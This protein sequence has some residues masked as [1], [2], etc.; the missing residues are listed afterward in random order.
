MII[1][2][3]RFDSYR[4]LWFI[5]YCVISGKIVRGPRPIFLYCKCL[6]I[7]LAPEFISYE[8]DGSITEKCIKNLIW[9]SS[10]MSRLGSGLTRYM[11]W[12]AV[13]NPNPRKQPSP[14]VEFSR[15]L[16]SKCH[17]DESKWKEDPRL[18]IT[19]V[20]WHKYAQ[21]VFVSLSQYLCMCH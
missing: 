20:P 1:S 5:F 7:I 11:I 10:K 13:P 3:C 12:L 9:T 15:G 21:P 8:T 6:S 2:V 19:F 4:K 14:P 17:C 16:L 18:I